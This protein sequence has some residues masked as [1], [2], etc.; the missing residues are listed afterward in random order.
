M[1]RLARRMIWLAASLVWVTA[2]ARFV[3]VATRAETGWDT[4]AESWRSAI[5]G[6]LG[7]NNESISHREP[8]EQAEY[9]LH[10]VDAVLA[11][12]P[13]SADLCLGAACVLDSPGIDFV[14]KHVKQDPVLFSI[15]GIPA[16]LDENAVAAAKSQFQ[17]KCADRCLSLA[18]RACE[19][20]PGKPAVWRFRALLQFDP[21]TRKPRRAD[22]V[23]V[24]DECA[25]HDR[26]N[27]LYDYL[28]ALGLWSQSAE[29]DFDP[30]AKTNFQYALQI[31]DATKF[32][33]GIERFERG[34]RKFILVLGEPELSA[35]TEFL[36]RSQLP[37]AEQDDVAVSRLLTLRFELV[38]YDLYRWQNVRCDMA[39]AKGDA[40]ARANILRQQLHLI[41]QAIG[42]RETPAIRMLIE[43]S[44]HFLPN[45]QAQM[46]DIERA[47][48]QTIA[49]E[50]LENLMNRRQR[51]K[52]DAAVWSRAIGMWA[53]SRKVSLERSVLLA[54]LVAGSCISVTA[55]I[56][57]AVVSL[58][59]A[60]L[61]VR[62]TIAGPTLGGLAATDRLGD[63]RRSYLSC[64]WH[65]AGRVD[66]SLG[67]IAGH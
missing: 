32:Q 30:D 14:L 63:C 57:I 12:Q 52:F 28:L 51:L 2:V 44:E 18:A 49:Q 20:E 42:P 66:S 43:V 60:L 39:E 22:W 23:Q 62:R 36:A 53:A 9:W 13:E 7:W 41:A 54:T 19:L 4:V 31:H 65:G 21:D 10:E 8:A 55:T 6:P 33:R 46:S 1:K 50:E 35:I 47:H 37:I 17:Q 29:Y 64:I 24:L 11:R 48:P 61:L 5:T 45:L 34:Q 16:Q 26:D 59:I 38:F 40:P 27:A 58:L 3:V 25:M 56:A 67:A 15:P